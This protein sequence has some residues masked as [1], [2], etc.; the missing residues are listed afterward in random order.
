M[1]I[2]EVS[3]H[4]RPVGRSCGCRVLPECDIIVQPRL[5]GETLRRLDN[6]KLILVE[7]LPTCW[8]RIAKYHRKDCEG[9][10]PSRTKICGLTERESR[11]IRARKLLL[12]RELSETKRDKDFV[13]L[14]RLNETFVWSVYR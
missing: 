5:A 6:E 7:V 11:P 9:F 8:K 1:K 13:S 14:V 2:E 3:I 4:A 10:N 12:R